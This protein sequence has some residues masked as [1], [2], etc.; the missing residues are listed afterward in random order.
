MNS[1][2]VRATPYPFETPQAMWLRRQAKEHPLP[3]GN[4]YTPR[5]WRSGRALL[6]E[7]SV[8]P[9]ERN[10]SAATRRARLA[11]LRAKA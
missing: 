2:P 6:L 10:L 4:G 3:T 8:P 5:P 1:H 7:T 9:Q 11:V